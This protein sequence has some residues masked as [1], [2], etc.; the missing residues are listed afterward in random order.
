MRNHRLMA[1][2]AV[3]VLIAAA[4]STGEAEP[5]STTGAAAA[6]EGSATPI[7]ISV[8]PVE[9]R[10]LA[11]GAMAGKRVAFVPIAV[12]GFDLAGQWIV[13][14][15]R[16]FDDVGI[17]FTVHDPSFDTDKMVQIIDG[18]I[19]E[20]VDALI[21]HNPDVG[22]LSEQIRKA[23]DAGIYVVVLNLLSNE[24]S[25]VFIGG[26]VTSMARDIA[27][28]GAD[29]CEARGLTKVAVVDIWGTDSWS[30][31]ANAGWDPVFEERGL[32]VVSRQQGQADPG[33]AAEIATAVLQQNDDLCAILS[34]WD[35]PALGIGQAVATAGRTGDVAVYAMDSS[36]LT[37]QAIEAGTVTA[38]AAYHVP[39][40]GVAAAVAVQSLFQNDPGAGTT[41]AVTYVPHTIVNADNYQQVA[42]A[43]YASQ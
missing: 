30:I 14:M 27:N 33:V 16:T 24:S 3:I 7:P 23:R 39:G 26:D 29:D 5:S 2:L 19:S 41:R 31:Q 4:C 8:D 10:K 37:C 1:L 18:L 17:E 6:T 32:E 9:G 28:Y 40:M 22:V 25:D 15:Q 36:S 42:M 38:A 13:E 34:A 43:C 11:L 35:I 12:E 20:G 21:L